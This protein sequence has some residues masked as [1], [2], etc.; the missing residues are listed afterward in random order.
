MD[1]H[2]ELRKV[3]GVCL[4][5]NKSSSSSPIESKKLKSDQFPNARVSAVWGRGPGGGSPVRSHRCTDSTRSH[6]RKGSPIFLCT[7]WWHH[8]CSG[9]KGVNHLEG[10]EWL[11]GE[12][13]Q[14]Q[15]AFRG[16][17]SPSQQNPK[18]WHLSETKLEA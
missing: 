8:R 2:T 3:I 1:S 16:N 7:R 11:N 6:N 4:G 15:P 12:W 5:D 13:P 17:F 9:R 14:R 10:K 18:K